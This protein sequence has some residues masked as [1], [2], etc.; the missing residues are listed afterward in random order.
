M[1]KNIIAATA[2]VI[3]SATISLFAWPFKAYAATSYIEKFPT[4]SNVSM[5]YQANDA[6]SNPITKDQALAIA[7]KHA[8]Y[9]KDDVLFTSVEKDF[10]DGKEI[11]EVE[12]RVGFCEYSY[13]IEI[14]NGQILDFDID[15]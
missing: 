10:D 7:L 3:T 9:E 15:D 8:G 13:D 14:S 11:Y 12:F 1:K 6:T 5:A 2:I 4:T